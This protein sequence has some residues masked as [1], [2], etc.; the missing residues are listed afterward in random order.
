MKLKRRPNWE[1]LRGAADELAGLLDLNY[2]AERGRVRELT[3]SR[4]ESAGDVADQSECRKSL[5]VAARMRGLAQNVCHY[6]A[7]VEEEAE[8]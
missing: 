4:P 3:N 5:A 2:E 1:S 6:A 7:F 8:E